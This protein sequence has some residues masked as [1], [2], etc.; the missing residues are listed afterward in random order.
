MKTSE[1]QAVIIPTQELP[2]I[3]VP[4]SVLPG[5]DK[6]KLKTF[7]CGSGEFAMLSLGQMG[8]VGSVSFRAILTE[9]FCRAWSIL[10]LEDQR[11]VFCTSQDVQLFEGAAFSLPDK[12]RLYI[13]A[14]PGS[15]CQIPEVSVDAKD[16]FSLKM[17]D[18]VRT[19][20]GT[21]LG[22]GWIDDESFGPSSVFIFKVL[23]K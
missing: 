14:D 8:V 15:K 4:I 17:R 16:V 9:S 21:G 22:S 12:S 7:A 19:H 13:A 23:K 2:V 10:N 5:T 1:K 20:P 3:V 6:L 11:I 18:L